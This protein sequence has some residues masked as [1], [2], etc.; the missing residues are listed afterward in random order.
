M[1]L[2]RTIVLVLLCAACADRWSVAVSRGSGEIEGPK[3]GWDTEDSRIELGLSGPLTIP[4]STGRCS[5]PPP[6]PEWKPCA[7]PAPFALSN[8]VEKGAASPPD[9]GPDIPWAMLVC[10]AVGALGWGGGQAGVKK[11]RNRRSA[12]S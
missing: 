12:S 9:D 8:V 4:K 7:E 10:T 2:L 3:S 11:Y 1:T 6:A 5:P